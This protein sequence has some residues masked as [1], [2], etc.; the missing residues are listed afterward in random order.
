MVITQKL[1]FIVINKTA[2][3]LYS[4]ITDR[5]YRS[6]SRGR[7]KWKSLI[8]PSASMQPN[9]NKEGYNADADYVREFNAEFSEARIGILGNEKND[10]RSCDSRIRFGTG[11]YSH[12]NNTCR[13]AARP[14][15]DN[16]DKNT[17]AMGYILVL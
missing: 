16:G 15:G 14:G 17:N 8:G 6:T 7:Q 3:S 5:K 1:R 9:C 13:N 10:C 12:E 4:L 2:G 11:G